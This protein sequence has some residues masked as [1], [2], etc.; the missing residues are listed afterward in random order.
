EGVDFPGLAAGADQVAV[1]GGEERVG[2]ARGVGRGERAPDVAVEGGQVGGGGRR[3][4]VGGGHRV[5]APCRNR[6]TWSSGV[7]AG[8][9]RR[10]SRPN[11]CA[12]NMSVSTGTGSRR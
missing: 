3:A 4:G 11:S 6:S 12:K 7:T 5:T 9:V 8:S 1:V 10:R 2:V